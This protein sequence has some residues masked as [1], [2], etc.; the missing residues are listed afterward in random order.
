MAFSHAWPVVVGLRPLAVLLSL[1]GCDNPSG[2]VGGSVAVQTPLPKMEMPSEEACRQWAAELEDAVVQGDVHAFNARFDW[3]TFLKITTRGFEDK[4]EFREGFCRGF[5]NNLGGASGFAAQL[6]DNPLGKVRYRLLRIHDV[7]G[8]RYALFRA[9][10]P[11][12]GLNYHDHLLALQ[13]SGGARAVD[14]SVFISGERLSETVRRMF[15]QGLSGTS[16]S[17]LDRLTGT[18]S[19]FVANAEKIKQMGH[20]FRAAQYREVLDAFETLPAS[21]QKEKMILLLRLGA[22][23]HLENDE[24]LQAI[25]DFRQNNPG[26][27]SLDLI[28]LDQF[29]LKREFS[30]ARECLDRLDKAIGGDP[31]LDILRANS[32]IE[33]DKHDAAKKHASRALTDTDIATDACWILVT[34]ALVQR[35]HDETTRLLNLLERDY[36]VETEDLTTIPEYAEYV[37]SPQYQKWL[38]GRSKP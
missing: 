33:E 25:T 4:T 36:G 26:D 15:V 32:Y 5:R 31:Y 22:A 30:K 18:E 3:E 10:L 19:D 11:D 9:L 24:Y 38:E 2:G 1:C 16:R 7:G 27:P 23:A 6:C 13:P 14:L 35:D 37:K 12:G 29:F 21:L 34:L 8:Q 28:M 17:L 20:L